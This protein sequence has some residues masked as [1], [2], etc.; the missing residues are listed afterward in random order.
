MR[1]WKAAEMCHRSNL[2]SLETKHFASF[3]SH[4]N[5]IKDTIITDSYCLLQYHQLTYI[6]IHI[7]S[8]HSFHFAFPSYKKNTWKCTI[9]VS[10][11][12]IDLTNNR[13]DTIQEIRYSFKIKSTSHKSWMHAV[14]YIE[15]YKK[16]FTKE[17][18]L[19]LHGTVS[20]K[21]ELIKT[22]NTSKAHYQEIVSGK[23]RSWCFYT[24]WI[25]QTKYGVFPRFQSS[26]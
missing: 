19:C 1:L 6:C 20:M 23:S 24:D 25:N 11:S 17:T 8:I 9:Q 14:Q 18:L 12:L 7:H 26:C 3:R 2:R 13:V 4:N 15:R 10:S 5:L 16:D 21:L 22:G